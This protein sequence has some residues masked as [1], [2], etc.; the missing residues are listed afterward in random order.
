MLR[1]QISAQACRL[2]DAWGAESA[3][4]DPAVP[5]GAETVWLGRAGVIYSSGAR[6]RACEWREDKEQIRRASAASFPPGPVAPTAQPGL[7][8]PVAMEGRGQ[9]SGEAGG[10]TG[11]PYPQR[12]LSLLGPGASVTR[13]Q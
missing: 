9:L 1:E 13:M 5:A 7:T 2:R 6:P 3:G 11:T 4:G 8:C 12:G 10:A